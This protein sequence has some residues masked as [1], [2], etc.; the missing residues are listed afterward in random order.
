MFV[1]RRGVFVVCLGGG[2]WFIV[3]LC[4]GALGCKV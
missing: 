2:Q 1:E 4:V 3:G